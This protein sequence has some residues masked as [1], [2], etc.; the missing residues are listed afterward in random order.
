MHKIQR[1][2]YLYLDRTASFNTVQ[3]V[4]GFAL[5]KYRKNQS[6]MLAPPTE[7]V[8]ASLEGAETMYILMR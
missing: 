4:T 1:Y 2:R 7:A 5:S 8:Y 6:T 3:G